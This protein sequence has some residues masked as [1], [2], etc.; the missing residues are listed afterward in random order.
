[1]ILP[2]SPALGG[3]TAVA[4]RKINTL[5]IAASRRIR[6]GGTVNR[7]GLFLP[8]VCGG[9]PVSTVRSAPPRLPPAASF[10]RK[11]VPCGGRYPASAP[12]TARRQPA[13]IQTATVPN[14]RRSRRSG[15]SDGP[16][17][18]F[19]F[20]GL[21]QG[22]SSSSSPLSAYAPIRRIMPGRSPIPLPA[23]AAFRAPQTALFRKHYFAAA[24]RERGEYSGCRAALMTIATSR[25]ARPI[26][27]SISRGGD[28]HRLPARSD[29]IGGFL[30]AG[31]LQGDG[32]ASTTVGTPIP[33]TGTPSVSA[34]SSIRLFPHPRSGSDPGVT[35]LERTAQPR[36]T[37]RGERI[38]HNYGGGPYHAAH[39]PA[40]FPRFPSRYVRAH[41]ERARRRTQIVQ[42][43]AA[44][45][46]PPLNMAGG[47]HHVDGMRPQ[48][49]G[50]DRF[51]PQ[52]ITS[53]APS[54]GSRARVPL[55][56]ALPFPPFPLRRRLK[57]AV[58]P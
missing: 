5:L 19:V 45:K 38:H 32:R 7:F 51:V 8:A 30:P 53:T 46:F 52:S 36:H 16:E 13:R 23:P 25:D 47:H 14:D 9:Y 35:E 54:G 34:F 50:R 11:A 43:D 18:Y 4:R 42:S 10:R 24:I 27:R 39:S 28:H 44:G 56:A 17:H 22:F 37:A 3:M 21:G 49:V 1:M 2:P 48:R 40:R 33:I 26:S 6:H 12:P 31:Q 15:R 41:R 55:P 58:R 20:V 57:A 29:R